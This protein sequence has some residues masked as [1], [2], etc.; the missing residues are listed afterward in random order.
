MRYDEDQDDMSED[1]LPSVQDA[2]RKGQKIGTSSSQRKDRPQ[3][4]G[5]SRNVMGVGPIG[6]EDDVDDFIDDDD[7]E[8]SQA[9]EYDENGDRIRKKK[10]KKSKHPSSGGVENGK[11]G[12]DREAWEELNDI[13]GDGED[14]G[15]A[16]KAS[17]PDDGGEEGMDIDDDGD[18][19]EEEEDEDGEETGGRKEKKKKGKKSG[20]AYKDVSSIYAH[21]VSSSLSKIALA[22]QALLCPFAS[23]DLRT[24]S[25]R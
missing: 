15:W 6:D 16:L 10:N 1:D 17:G 8:D 18:D 24:C 25:N 7:S 11:A 13:F 3:N 12:I 19:E 9:G 2:M 20:V 22:E 21:R 4:G 23:P 14:Y 5:P